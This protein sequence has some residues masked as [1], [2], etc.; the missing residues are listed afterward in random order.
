MFKGFNA[1]A[2]SR[3]FANNEEC[4]YYL[5]GIK[6]GKG[7]QCSK[8]SCNESYSE[9][10]YYYRRCKQCG[11]DA[12]VTANTMFHSIMMPILNPF[13][14]A[15]RITT[16]KKGMSTIELGTEVGVQQKTSWLF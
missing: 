6:W 14:M 16:K 7:F 9:R 10:I 2:F 12:S 8:C 13:H 1:I 15:F 5:I 11:Y 3:K 4:Y